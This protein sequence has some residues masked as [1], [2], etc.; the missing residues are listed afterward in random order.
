MQ[1]GGF[2]LDANRGYVVDSSYRRM[3]RTRAI[4]CFG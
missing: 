2:T 3:R 1:G 4:L